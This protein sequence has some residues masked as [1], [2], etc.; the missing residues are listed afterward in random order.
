MIKAG[1]SFDRRHFALSL[2][3]HKDWHFNIV[4]NY[5]EPQLDLQ[6][7]AWIKHYVDEGWYVYNVQSGGKNEAGNLSAPLRHATVINKKMTHFYTVI[8]NYW[9]YANEVTKKGTP[10]ARSIKVTDD[11]NG[12]REEWN[13]EA[14]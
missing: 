9:R 7:K 3:T 13:N 1:K 8:T 5:P 11:Y 2:R 4:E 10:T 6:E 12:I 14:D